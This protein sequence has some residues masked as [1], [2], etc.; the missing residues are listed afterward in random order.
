MQQC[1]T[2]RTV[3]SQPLHPIQVQNGALS[4]VEIHRDTV[5]WLVE[6]TVFLRQLSYAIKTQLKEP[7]APSYLIS[8]LYSPPLCLSFPLLASTPG[9]ETASPS[10]EQKKKIF[11]P[12][13]Q[14]NWPRERWSFHVCKV[15]GK[16]QA[17][18]ASRFILGHECVL[19]CNSGR[20]QQLWY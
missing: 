1:P 8:D 5:L 13:S 16:L 18:F 3:T 11:S 17:R 2:L 10:S 20:R 7:K 14:E 9:S 19:L 12:S 15:L 4:L 6:I